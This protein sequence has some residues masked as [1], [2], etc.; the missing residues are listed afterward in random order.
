MKVKEFFI[1]VWDLAVIFAFCFIF[2]ILPEPKEGEIYE[3]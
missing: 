2:T 1:L 3:V